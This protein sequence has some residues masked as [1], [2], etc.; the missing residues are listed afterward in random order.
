MQYRMNFRWRDVVRWLIIV[1]TKINYNY[2]LIQPLLSASLQ[3]WNSKEI[4]IFL[5]IYIHSIYTYYNNEMSFPVHWKLPGSKNR[6]TLDNYPLG[7]FRNQMNFWDFHVNT[8]DL[9]GNTFG[10]YHPN[11]ASMS[12]LTRI[13]DSR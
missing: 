6:P 11:K 2:N 4:F 13:G 3:K 12:P 5:N 8:M 1:K 7:I 9:L 10:Y